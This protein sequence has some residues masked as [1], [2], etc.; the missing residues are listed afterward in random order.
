[1]DYWYSFNYRMWHVST[2]ALFCLPSVHFVQPTN[3]TKPLFPALQI[4]GTIVHDFGDISR[5][6]RDGLLDKIAEHSATPSEKL[7]LGKV[8]RQMGDINEA[9]QILETFIPESERRYGENHIRKYT[10]FS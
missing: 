1:M 2:M 5:A 9:Q 4:L 7:L 8:H 3:L 6:R 10:Y